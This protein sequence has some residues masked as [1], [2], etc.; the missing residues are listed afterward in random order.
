MRRRPGLHEPLLSLVFV[1]RS[2][3]ALPAHRHLAPTDPAVAPSAWL[4]MNPL[5]FF[6]AVAGL[7]PG[8]LVVSLDRAVH[9]WPAVLA[10]SVLVNLPWLL[11]AFAVPYVF[12]RY[13]RTLAPGVQPKTTFFE[14][15]RW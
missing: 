5:Q 12:F 1:G 7:L 14:E 13:L 9:A 15:V 10:A 4:H 11:V 2:F 8:F 6:G 3:F